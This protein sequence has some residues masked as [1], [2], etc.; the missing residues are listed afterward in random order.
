MKKILF[1]FI[2]LFSPNYFAQVISG[3]VIDSFN[4]IGI[5]NAKVLV[6]NLNS[7]FTDSTFTNSSGNWS[8]NFV[9]GIHDDDVSPSDFSIAQNYPNPF[10]PS[11][12]IEF[13]IPKSSNVQILIH[14]I[15][16][17]LIDLRE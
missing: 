16:G 13:N 15:L 10:N 9:T 7:G 1:Y 2:V 3:T 17:Q 5:A 8:Y 11:T 14:D 6:T 12:T 4:Q